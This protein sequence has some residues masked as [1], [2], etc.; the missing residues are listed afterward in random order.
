MLNKRLHILVEE[1]DREM[2]ERLASIKNISVAELVRGAVR[3][4]ISDGWK[5]EQ[6]KRKLAWSQISDWRKKLQKF[7]KDKKPLT[8]TQIRELINYGQKN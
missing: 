6:E 7:N 2:L 5:E 3:N 8:V 1:R 4:S